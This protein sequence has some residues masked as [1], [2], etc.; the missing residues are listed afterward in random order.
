MQNKS[1]LM[2]ECKNQ[3]VEWLVACNKAF[4]KDVL[5]IGETSRQLVGPL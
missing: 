1:T 4:V 3:G 2:E 5:R